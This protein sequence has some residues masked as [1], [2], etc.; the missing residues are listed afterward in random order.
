MNS[1]EGNFLNLP[2]DLPV[3]FELFQNIISNDNVSIERII[4]TGQSTPEGQWLEQDSNEWVLLIQ[5]VAELKFEDGTIRS[6][7]AGDYICIPQNTKHKVTRTT[8]DPPCVW[9]A[10]HYS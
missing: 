2:D 4:S 7:A 8:S 9:L 6:L 10:I 5:G 3:N 1:S